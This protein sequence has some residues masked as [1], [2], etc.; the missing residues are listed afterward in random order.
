MNVL[1]RKTNH[2]T[3]DI[4]KLLSAIAD[5]MGGLLEN[6]RLQEGIT[7]GQELERRRDTF[8]S[9]A[10]H[11]L[12][13]PM[14]TI[15]GF[16][17]LLLSRNPPEATRR[18]WLERIHLHSKRLADIVDNLLNVSRIQSGKLAVNLE[19]LPLS[20]VIE[21]V[22]GAARTT[23]EIH[24]FMVD[25]SPDTPKVVADRDKLAEILT[26]LLSNA[27]KYS[28]GGGQITVSARLQPGKD[29]VVVAVADQGLGISRRDREHLF[30]TFHRIRRPETDGI[31]GTGLGLYIVK[32]LAGLMRGEV[33]LKSQLGKGSTL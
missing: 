22:V 11:E 14:T 7:L 10:S 13:T 9:I 32:E 8:V 31:S 24:E 18:E 6:A 20:V 1:S 27:V 33:W 25:I 4:V 23:T 19:Q 16:S 5:G 29:R 12:R 2:F 3:A 26:N 15:L 21:E 28:P 30:T 17:E